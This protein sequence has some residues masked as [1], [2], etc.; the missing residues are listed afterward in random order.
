MPI[1]EYAGLYLGLLMMFHVPSDTVACELAWSADSVRWERVDPG[2]ALIPL[3]AAGACDSGCVYAAAAHGAR[4]RNGDYKA[5]GSDRRQP[6]D[7]RRGGCWRGSR[8]RC[9]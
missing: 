5:R 1:V 2:N 7:E 6:A 9:R 3:G 4:R 8:G